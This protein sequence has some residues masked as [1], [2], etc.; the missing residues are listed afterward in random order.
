MG[1]HD[2]IRSM[3]GFNLY[4]ADTTKQHGRLDTFNGQEF[5]TY[6]VQHDGRRGPMDAQVL[7]APGFASVPVEGDRLLIMSKQGELYAIGGA[8]Q[9]VEESLGLTAGSRAVYSTDTSGVLQAIIRLLADG[10][11]NITGDVTIGESSPGF[12]A[13]SAKV[14]ALWLSFYNMFSGW[15]PVA[16]DGGTALKTAFTTAFPSAPESV[17]ATKLKTE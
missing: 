8:C 12:V 5:P 13:L 16:Q 15:T 14:D 7:F 10:K 11:I 6:V 2:T 17:A 1:L 3:S 9:N 4:L